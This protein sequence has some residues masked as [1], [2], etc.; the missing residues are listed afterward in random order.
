MPDDALALV[1]GDKMVRR[2]ELSPRPLFADQCF[3]AYNF[4]GGQLHL[5]LVDHCELVV[6]NGLEQVGVLAGAAAAPLPQDCV[7]VFLL[8]GVHELIGQDNLVLD[9]VFPLL[10]EG[11]DGDVHVFILVKGR[12]DIRDFLFKAG[13]GAVDAQGDELIAANAE[14]AVR[15][16]T[17]QNHRGLGDDVVPVLVAVAVVGGLEAVDVNVDNAQG[18]GR[19]QL[20]PV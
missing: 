8:F 17:L 15:E 14:G 18:V 19:R 20:Q 13:L 3:D 7:V 16:K 1:P 6:L 9:V 5:G 12:L 2:D 10:P 11:A 4:A